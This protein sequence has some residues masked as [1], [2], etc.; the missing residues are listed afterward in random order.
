MGESDRGLHPRSIGSGDTVSRR[1]LT[2][3]EEWDQLGPFWFNVTQEMSNYDSLARETDR[4]GQIWLGN[5]WENAYNVQFF[6]DG[7]GRLS[8]II[9]RN[10]NGG[11]WQTSSRD[12]L[13]YNAYGLV[14]EE[15]VD[16]FNG[17]VWVPYQRYLV[18][19]DPALRPVEVV[20]M[21]WGGSAWTNSVRYT[22]AFD[23]EGRLIE[24]A[25]QI[26][27]ASRWTNVARSLF[28]YDTGGNL[29]TQTDQFWSGEVWVNDVRYTMTYDGSGSLVELLQEI[30]IAGAWWY[31]LREIYNNDQAGLPGDILTQYWDGFVWVDERVEYIVY[32]GRNPVEEFSQHWTGSEWVNERKTS[33]AWMTI[34]TPSEVTRLYAVGDGWNMV[35]LPLEVADPSKEAVY[36]AAV[37]SAF[38]FDAGY[39]ASPTIETGKGYWLKFSGGQKV[40]LTGGLVTRDTIPVTAGWNMVGSVGV[41]VPAS[42]VGSIPGGLVSSSFFGFDAGYQAAAVIEPGKGYWVKMAEAGQLVMSGSADMPPATRL[43][44]TLTDA[45]PPS[46]PSGTADDAGLP[47]GTSLA[48]NYPNPFNPSTTIEYR[49]AGPGR[50]RLTVHDIVGREVAVL[51]DEVREAGEGRA[52]LDGSRLSSGVYTYRLLAGSQILTGRMLLVR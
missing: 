7:N 1:I 5:A 41:P 16:V 39:S 44:M 18:A 34:V 2:R 19:Y 15:L 50:V 46:P 45:E 22:L 24:S 26:W 38:A 9:G 20:G 47:A 8:K 51:V 52:V 48:H 13:L 49:L 33:Y 14:V 30:R 40:S 4:I 42:S 28:T 23:S 6:Y 36:P 12:S 29:A 10:W 32:D 3:H 35:S 37:S 43:S 17:S 27:S 11:L 31:D 21:A 25:F